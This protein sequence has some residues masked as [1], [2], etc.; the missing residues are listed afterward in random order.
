MPKKIHLIFALLFLCTV[1]TFAEPRGWGTGI[2]VMDGAFGAHARKGFLLG[3][4]QQYAI[5]LQGGLYNETK[6][7][8]RF[9]ADFHYVLT[10]TSSFS[11]YPLLGIDLAI[12]N[13]NNRLGANL[14]GGALFDLNTETRL[15]FEVKYVTGDW[16][17]FSFIAGIYF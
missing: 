7:T 9:D 13:K 6:W 12:R 17:G 4:E 2:G 11:V 5:V 16:D 14:G 3:E 8:G 1:G 10:P 15:F